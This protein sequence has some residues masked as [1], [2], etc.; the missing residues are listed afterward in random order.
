LRRK[1]ANGLN[2]FGASALDLFASGMGVF[3]LI[4][5]IIFPYYLKIDPDL[6][7]EIG[8][9]KVEKKAV[10]EENKKLREEQFS[11]KEM[12]E[13]VKALS[14]MV[15]S[16]ELEKMDLIDENERFRNGEINLKDIL[17]KLDVFK[18]KLRKLEIENEVLKAENEQLKAE[19]EKYQEVLNEL[20]ALQKVVEEQ[21]HEIDILKAQLKKMQE[22]ITQKDQRIEM[23]EKQLEETA[24]S[25]RSSWGGIISSARKNLLFVVDISASM[26]PFKTNVVESIK[27]NIEG[28][29]YWIKSGV[30]VTVLGYDG[31]KSLKHVYSERNMKSVDYKFLYQ[32]N[33]L[34]DT[35]RNAGG[36]YG[37][38][39]YYA[40]NK[41]L[42]YNVKKITVY[43][44]SLPTDANT[45]SLI[46]KITEQNANGTGTE[47]YTASFG[48]AGTDDTLMNFLKALA[49]YNRGTFMGAYDIK[50]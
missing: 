30:N 21:K 36:Y 31:S 20:E 1:K 18:N 19:N 50:R 26:M 5:I 39:L 27:N 3:L 49:G 22:L 14:Q 28:N 37:S 43:T 8:K 25:S 35:N 9:I 4:A 13:K 15:K 11:I 23:L 29:L 6:I 47:I 44:N 7:R 41:A 34:F 10:E 48:R 45:E 17:E 2:I 16:L 32:L 42:E 40:L 12:L 46:R 38:S 33:L 24:Y